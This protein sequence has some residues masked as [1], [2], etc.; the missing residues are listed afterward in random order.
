MLSKY[1]IS[2]GATESAETTTENELQ[3]EVRCDKTPWH[4]V[5]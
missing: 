4:A 2:G 1:S 3:W 5:V